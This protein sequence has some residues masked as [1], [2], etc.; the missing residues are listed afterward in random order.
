MLLSTRPPRS[1][2]HHCILKSASKADI[3][4]LEVQLLKYAPTGGWLPRASGRKF[5]GLGKADEEHLWSGDFNF[6]VAADTQFGFLDDPDWGGAGTGNWQEERIAAEML[7]ERVNAMEPLPKML[8]ICG[9]L[10]HNMPE[11]TN[12]KYTNPAF[13]KRQRDDFKEVFSKLNKDITLILI[14]KSRSSQSSIRTSHVWWYR[15]TMA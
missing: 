7:V 9:D 15:G 10:V 11:S 3:F 12:T 4:P 1:E 13:A 14:L 2:D 6:V 8:V 5:I